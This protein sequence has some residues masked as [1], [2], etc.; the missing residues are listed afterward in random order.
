MH[1]HAVCVLHKNM[2]PCSCDMHMQMHMVHVYAHVHAHVQYFM[3]I[4]G[5]LTTGFGI[6]FAVLLPASMTDPWY[7]A[8]GDN[9]LWGC[10]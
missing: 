4:M 5:V 9:I 7:H 1:M 3:V 10:V 6:S 8:F 2:T